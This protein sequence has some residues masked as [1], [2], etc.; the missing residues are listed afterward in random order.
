MFLSQVVLCFTQ[1]KE[2][3]GE[4]SSA[5]GLDPVDEQRPSAECPVPVSLFWFMNHINWY[6]EEI[7]RIVQR[8]KVRMKSEVLVKFEAE[9]EDGTPAD[10]LSEFTDLV[11]KCLPDSSGSV[12]PLK[13]LD[14]D[15]WR[16]ALRVISKHENKLLVTTTSEEMNVFG[17]ITSRDVFSNTINAMQQTN[18][19]D[20][21]DFRPPSPHLK[22]KMTINDPLTDAGLTMGQD[23]WKMISSCHQQV[24]TIKSKFNVDFKETSNGRGVV[25]V[26]AVYNR[27]GGNAAM[28]SHAVRALLHLYQKVLTSPLPL[29]LPSG[30]AGFNPTQQNDDTPSGGGATGGDDDDDEKCSICL[31]AFTNKKQLKCK[32]E[33]C[34]DCLRE[35]KKHNGPIC[36]I[37]KDVFGVMEGNQPDG[38]M[39]WYKSPGSLPGF[40]GCGH[41]SITYD[42]PSGTQTVN[43]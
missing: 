22:I 27:A 4:Q 14:P 21:G 34:E 39:T 19:S 9:Q 30:A 18:E 32:H 35:T 40:P 11:Q 15:N 37:C 26:K 36:P 10:A 42:I 23:Q 2:Q 24:A 7:K 5:A 12:V 13:C 25:N 29:A 3:L 38:R 43:V 16:D 6:K 17:P 41:I 8:N 20:E 28:E 33:F 31:D 1:D